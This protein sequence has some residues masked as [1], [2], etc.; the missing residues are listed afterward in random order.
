[1]SACCSVSSQ[2][3]SAQCTAPSQSA[4]GF[5]TPAFQ[6]FMDSL[7]V[8][9]ARGCIPRAP[10]M[11]LCSRRTCSPSSLPAGALCQ[12]ALLHCPSPVRAC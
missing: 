11:L 12:M 2:L 9:W 4:D 10:E 8:K 7:L 6:V 3:P 1:M 5:H